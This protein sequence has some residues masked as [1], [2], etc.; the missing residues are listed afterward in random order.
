MG[1]PDCVYDEAPR[2]D[3]SGLGPLATD[4]GVPVH[5]YDNA[6]NLGEQRELAVGVTYDAATPTM[7]AEGVEEA[8]AGAARAESAYSRGRCFASSSQRRRS[9]GQGC[10]A[11]SPATQGTR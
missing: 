3:E 9:R 10:P 1:V 11:R 2:A 4:G 6:V 7:A 5:R 8:A